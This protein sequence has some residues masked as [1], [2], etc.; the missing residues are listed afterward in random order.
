VVA[1]L[2]PTIRRLWLRIGASQECAAFKVPD[3]YW[4]MNKYPETVREVVVDFWIDWEI[5]PLFR[6][7]EDRIAEHTK[8]LAMEI[9]KERK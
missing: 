6:D 8:K 9:E 5:Q 1:R 7:V 3:A 2:V 4:Q